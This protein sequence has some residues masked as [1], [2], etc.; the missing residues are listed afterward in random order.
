VISYGMN[1]DGST[2]T[3]LT[4]KEGMEQ[5]VVYWVP[6]LAVCGMN[7]YTGSEF[8]KWKNH[9]FLATLA[10][11]ELR[12]LEVVNGKVVYQ[13]ILFKNLGRIRH[14]IG[15]PDGALYVLLPNRIARLS[16]A[17]TQVTSAR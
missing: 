5:P 11:Q 13:E 1:Y 3:E 8:P 2:L 16:A 9:L 4:A 15:G 12:R 10:A 7:F 14:V 6:S 17:S